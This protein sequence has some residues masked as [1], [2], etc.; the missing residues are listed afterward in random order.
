MMRPIEFYCTLFTLT[1]QN[2]FNPLPH[3]FTPFD[4]FANRA[5]PDQAGIVR[6]V[7]SGSTLF[8]YGNI[9]LI[10]HKQNSDT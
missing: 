6:A 8:A 2:R 5:D 7:R 1:M 10:L 9:C 3:R 4:T